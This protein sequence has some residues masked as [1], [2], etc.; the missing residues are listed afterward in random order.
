MFPGRLGTLPVFQSEFAVPINMGGYAN[1]SNVQIQTAYNCAVILRDVISPYL[2]RRMK[3]DVAADLP[4]KTEKVLFCKLTTIQREKYIKFLNSEDLKSIIDGKRNSLYGIDILRK[5]CNHPDL[6]ER[7]KLLEKPGYKYGAPEKSG[8]MQ[9]VKA[10]VELWKS[11]GHRTLLFCQTRQTMDILQSFLSKLGIKF[12]KMDGTTPIALRQTLVD[13]FNQDVSFHVFLLTTRVGGLGVNLTGADRVIIFDPDWN[14]STDVQARERAWRL[15][16]KKQVSIYRL[17]TAGTIE[18]KIYHRQIFK[19]LLTNKILQDPKQRRFFKMNDL[20]DL[21]TLDES[22]DR[23][24]KTAS[25][26]SNTET[27]VQ[28]NHNNNMIEVDNEDDQPIT[29]KRRGKL[30]KKNQDDLTQIA[31]VDGV[32]GLEDYHAEE[33]KSSN[34]KESLNS[35]NIDDDRFMEGLFANSGVYSTLKH[36]SLVSGSQQDNVLIEREAS[37]VAKEAAAALRASSRAARKAE[38]GTPT[39]T[40]CFGTAGKRPLPNKLLASNNLNTGKDKRNHTGG[41]ATGSA[42]DIQNGIPTNSATRNFL[43][44]SKKE[45]IFG[46]RN[47]TQDIFATGKKSEPHRGSTITGIKGS[48]AS[49]TLLRGLRQKRQLEG[50]SVGDQGYKQIEENKL[51]KQEE[52]DVT[53]THIQQEEKVTKESTNV[54]NNIEDDVR[55]NQ[56]DVPVKLANESDNQQP[57]EPET[58]EEIKQDNLRRQILGYFQTAPDHGATSQQIITNCSK[59]SAMRDVRH[60]ANIKQL[61]KDISVWDRKQRKWILKDGFKI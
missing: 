34:D 43:S 61:I 59:G 50:S 10:L 15:G 26:F 25:M 17:M 41:L 42:K 36:D 27:R 33:G 57:P 30:Q 20:H 5:I 40:G 52:E 4:K 56:L 48:L 8:K 46:A 12:M 14:P 45:I 49:S 2:L 51:S 1:A 7:T 44:S 6:V 11:Q 29:S 31:A 55:D 9:V 54:E 38:I 28:S 13:S 22:D 23:N 60:V 58:R 47:K 53:E 3:A 32:A 24:I 21:F 35:E 16:Q 18:E 19:Q 37:R 39:W